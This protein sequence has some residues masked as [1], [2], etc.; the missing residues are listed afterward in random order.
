METLCAGTSRIGLLGI[1]GIGQRFCP[2]DRLV[3]EVSPR[4]TLLAGTSGIDQEY[5]YGR[6][7][8]F[9]QRFLQELVVL[10]KSASM[11]DIVGRIG[12]D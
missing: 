9:S 2:S 10:V 8:G 7:C 6:N 1:S 4:D 12:K 11:G 5:L 3:I